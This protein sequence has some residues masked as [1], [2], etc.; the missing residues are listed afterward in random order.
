[1]GE[2]QGSDRRAFCLSCIYGLSSLIGVGLAA[3]AGI[4]LLLPPKIRGPLGRCRRRRTDLSG[5]TSNGVG[6]AM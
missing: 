1:M 3:S 2:E 5:L 6:A 4:Y